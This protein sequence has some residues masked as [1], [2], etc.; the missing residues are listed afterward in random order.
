MQK[1]GAPCGNQTRPLHYRRELPDQTGADV[2]D[3]GVGLVADRL[4]GEGLSHGASASSGGDS[5]G[6][7]LICKKSILMKCWSRCSRKTRVLREH[8]LQRSEEHTSE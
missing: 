7:T 2:S 5:G 3:C 6:Q 8:L 1:C 4:G